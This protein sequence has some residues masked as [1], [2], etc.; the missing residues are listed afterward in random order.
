MNHSIIIPH[1]GATGGDVKIVEWLVK[2]GQQVKTGETIFVVETDKAT[3]EV[4]A[5]RDGYVRRILAPAGTEKSPGDV[6]GLLTDTADEAIEDPTV[7]APAKS[8]AAQPTAQPTPTSAATPARA[9]AATA[10]IAASP[11]ARRF[12]TQQGIDLATIRP[13]VGTVIQVSDVEAVVKGNRPP[14][15]Q[16]TR[17]QPVSA[18]RRAI[19]ERTRL[20]KSEIP[21]FYVSVDVDVT[22]LE[23]KRRELKA[24]SGGLPTPSLNDCVIAAAAR[25]LRETPE[26]NASYAGDKILRFDDVDL[27]VVIGLDDSIVVPLVRKADTLSLA[28]VAKATRLLRERAQAGSLTSADQ[29][30]GALTV[31][32]LGMYGVDGFV[33][34]IDP[35]QS[36]ALACGAARPRPWVV[37]GQLAVRTMMTTTLSVDH[38]LTDGVLAA[39]FMQRFKSTL[40]QP[41]QIFG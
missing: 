26:L 13:A 7:V 35:G 29:S 6:V 5:F 40:E 4:P 15:P 10:T 1:L 25:A 2:E 8:P 9:T 24:A 21:H 36:A 12:A 16:G 18:R 28:D 31:S 23:A 11:R 41:S 19:A 20:S 38:R 32:N 14:E 22:A 37:D 17:S 27:G 30:G 39:Q 3:D 34:V 33:A